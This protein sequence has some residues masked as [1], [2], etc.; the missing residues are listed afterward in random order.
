MKTFLQT[1]GAYFYDLAMGLGGLG[2]FALALADSSF[3][4]IPEGNDVLIVV[5]STG[6][7]WT[8]MFYY[9]A[10]TVAGSVAGC[11]LLYWVGR[12][13]GGFMHRRMN[14]EKLARV[15]RLYNR[16]GLWAV[17]IPSILPPPTPFK[18]FVF[19]A[20]LF[21]LPFPRFL[22]AVAVGRTI[23]YSMW[24]ILAVLYGEWARVLLEENIHTA[25][26]VLLVAFLALAAGWVVFRSMRQTQQEAS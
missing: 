16:R 25:G 15:E 8:R 10:M 11:T 22:T 7:T 21:A 3:L 9:V 4:S 17:L 12:R 5:L 19:A 1:A 23:R 24:G 13:G 20:G 6:A 2:L 18:V 26:V 14:P